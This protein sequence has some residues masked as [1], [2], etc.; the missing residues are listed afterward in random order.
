MKGIVLAAGAGSRLRP[1]TAAFSKHLLMVYSKPMIYYPIST[2]MLAGIRDILII[3]CDSDLPLYRK[4]LGN[5]SKFGCN[6]DYA[7]QNEATGIASALTIGRDFI[8]NSRVAVILGDNL[9]YG[10]GLI[11]T[12]AL[13][14]RSAKACIFGYEVADPENYGV[15]QIDLNGCIMKLVEKPEIKISNLAVTGL[16]FYP[17]DAVERV[18]ELS[19]SNRGELEITDLN[20]IYVNDKKIELIQLGRGFN[21]FDLGRVETLH[22]AASSVELIENR[23]N[24]LLGC[25]EEIAVKNKWK[26]K[27]EILSEVSLSKSFYDQKLKEFLFLEH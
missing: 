8:S 26:S 17:S 9:F 27:E 7:S 24:H 20:N 25:L 6:F 15:A 5:G 1:I 11:D 4:L 12:L 3:G 21:W 16:Y 19:P 14:K 23:T 10:A 22:A 2:L 13:A 18:K